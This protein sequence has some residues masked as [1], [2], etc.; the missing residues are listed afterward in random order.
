MVV[1]I[2]FTGLNYLPISVIHAAHEKLLHV[3]RVRAK[4]AAPPVSMD[5]NS[6]PRAAKIDLHRLLTSTGRSISS[7]VPMPT[8][9]KHL[10]LRFSR[11]ASLDGYIIWGMT[12]YTCVTNA[13][14]ELF[15]L[16]HPR[17]SLVICRRKRRTIQHRALTKTLRLTF[18]L[19]EAKRQALKI[20]TLTPTIDNE[21]YTTLH[22][23]YPQFS[24]APL[25]ETR[26]P[27]HSKLTQVT[28][29]SPAP[30]PNSIVPGY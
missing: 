21:Y 1:F 8:S 22:K 29:L 23:G 5:S 24:Y 10:G 28:V 14:K 6:S 26:I 16:F 2:K 7:S 9:T 4:L 19:C 15:V 30:C 17:T 25:R 20:E 13:E 27:S 18:S 11:G 3:F 12:F